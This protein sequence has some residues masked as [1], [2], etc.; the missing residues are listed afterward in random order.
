MTGPA[1]PIRPAGAGL[2]RSS[3]SQGR[4]EA[5][6]RRGAIVRASIS[7]GKMETET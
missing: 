7:K 6:R 3:W 5:A 1:H 4:G 2:T